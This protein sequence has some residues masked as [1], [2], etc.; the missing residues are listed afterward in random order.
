MSE[1]TI[2]PADLS[3]VSTYRHVSIASMSTQADNWD[4]HWSDISS[5]A[6]ISPSTAYRRRLI[7]KLLR[8]KP[9]GDGIRVLEIGSGTG[10]FAERFVRKYPRAAFLGLDNSATAVAMCAHKAPSARFL[11]RDLLVTPSLADDL[12]FGA[13]HA[14][15]SEVLEHVDVPDTL[16]RNSTAYMAPGC[17]VVIT[18]PGG[19]M[20]AFQRRIGHRKHYTA[21]ELRSLLNSAGFEA[22]FA[23]GVGFPFF[24]AYI[25]TLVWRGDKAMSDVVGEPGLAIRTASVVFDA[26][27][28]L[29][30]MRAGW[31]I[32]AV[33][34]YR[35]TP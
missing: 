28:R 7:E 5:S 30:S 17:R 6:D 2:G 24:N 11:Q 15:C 9:P 3:V 14:I 25:T 33:G 18:V 26:L 1:T 22:E 4:Q 29:N 8:I 10:S 31:Q 12:N 20:S 16:L 21:G 13:T 35:G 34:R 32:V 19:P 27:F 23:S